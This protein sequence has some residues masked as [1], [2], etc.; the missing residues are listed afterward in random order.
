FAAIRSQG[1]EAIVVAEGPG[2]FTH[3]QLIVQLVE[4]LRLPAVYPIRECVDLG[5]LVSYSANLPSLFRQAARQVAQILKGTKPG[6]IPFYRTT[7]FD[8]V[9]NLKT[10]KALGLTVP[11]TVLVRA[12]EV[13]E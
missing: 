7:E 9:I 10:A 1:V 8:L 11:A 13:I 3:R 5:G 4:D 6:D 2:S 12:N